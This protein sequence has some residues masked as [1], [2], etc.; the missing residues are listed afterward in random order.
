MSW[1]AMNYVRKIKRDTGIV[2]NLRFVLMMIAWRVPVGRMESIETPLSWLA[3]STGIN[4]RTVRRCRDQL[5]EKFKVVKIGASGRGRGEHQT[6]IIPRLAGP[7][8]MMA[9]DG[10]P[11]TLP[12]IS[13]PKKV[14]SVSTIPSVNRTS[15]QPEVSDLPSLD[16][17]TKYTCTT[18][19]ENGRTRVVAEVYEDA[20]VFLEWWQQT[21]PLHNDGARAIVQIE[22][23]APLVV[24]LLKHRSADRLQAMAIVLWTITVQEDRFIFDSDRGLKMLRHAADRLDRHAARRATAGSSVRADRLT[25][26][27]QA[28]RAGYK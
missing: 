18:S 15:V 25:P 14:G 27:E 13:P 10:K 3:N 28:R 2:G 23:D 1:A 11:D 22:R 8:F 6:Y 19:T 17:D 5:V 20:L 9:D 12:A 24:D 26:F 7:L 21:Y 4:E 16:L